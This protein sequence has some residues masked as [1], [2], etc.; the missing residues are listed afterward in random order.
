MPS[1]PI[2]LVIEILSFGVFLPLVVAGAVL[3]AAARLLK[4][5]GP[6]GAVLAVVAG[7]LVGNHFRPAAEY[8]IDSD[9]PLAVGELASEVYHAVGGGAEL[10]DE[11]VPHP[12]ARYW[13]PWAALLA[14]I[15]GVVARAPR[16]P[17]VGGWL[18]PGLVA[19]LVARL[20][21]PPSLRLE[22]P[23]LWPAFAAVVLAGWG[24]LD[25]FAEDSSGWVPF[26][27]G[28]VFAAGGVVLIHA[29][30]ARLTD[31]AIVLSGSWFGLALAAWWTGADVRSAVPVAAVSLPALM[32]VGQQSTYSDVPL[33]SFALVALAPLGLVPLLLPALRRRRGAFVGLGL[34]LLTSMIAVILAV[35]AESLSFD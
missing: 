31:L 17:L 3:Y 25:G 15:A 5:G 18:M 26:G 30:S 1:P 14:S 6:I 33:A 22:L 8:R 27:I 21:V 28:M 24:L 23:W 11:P 9:R 4:R 34:L 16:V 32:L 10:S 12:P 35:R 13:L 19:V 7:F 2:D 20:M 29:Q